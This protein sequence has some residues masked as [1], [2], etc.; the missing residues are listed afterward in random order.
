[1]KDKDTKDHE[2]VIPFPAPSHETPL[3]GEP[4]CT[5]WIPVAP[6]YDLNKDED[7]K[8]FMAAEI[9]IAMRIQG[10]FGVDEA[11]EWV[12][13]HRSLYFSEDDS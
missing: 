9:E 11:N 6:T 13:F 8:A 10:L 5:G 2:N 3:V 1:M 12:K 4:T 7:Y